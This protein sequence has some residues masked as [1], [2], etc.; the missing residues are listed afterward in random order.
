M[1]ASRSLGRAYGVLKL[2]RWWLSSFGRLLLARFSL[3]II[4]GRKIWSWSIGV[5]CA[6]RMRSLLITCFFIVSVHNC[7]GMPSSLVLAWRR[8]CLV[9]LWIFCSA[10]GRGVALEVPWFG[11]WFL[12]VSCGVYGPNGMRDFSRIL[13]E[14]WRIFYISF[15]LP[16]SLG[17][18]LSLPFL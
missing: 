4:W 10:G 11:R 1:L 13:K 2:R 8:Q 14:A 16:S 17:W 6:K 9:R 7:Y 3:W 15:S 12:I 18:Q 5:V